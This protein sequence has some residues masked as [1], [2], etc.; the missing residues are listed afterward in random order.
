MKLFISIL[1]VTIFINE[2]Y[3][4]LEAMRLH[5]YIKGKGSRTWNTILDV[6]LEQCKVFEQFGKVYVTELLSKAGKNYSCILEK[7]DY[8]VKNFEFNDDVIPGIPVLPYGDFR[9]ELSFYSNRTGLKV[10]ETCIN[11]EGEIVNKNENQR[12]QKFFG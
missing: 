7:G 6:L 11:Y 1:I 3:T 4:I 2:I 8:I 12:R 9:F 10:L 5:I